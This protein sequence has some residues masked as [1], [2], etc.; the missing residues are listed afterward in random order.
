MDDRTHLR[1]VL[2]VVAGQVRNALQEVVM[3]LKIVLKRKE[4][5]HIASVSKQS[6]CL[7]GFTV[8]RLQHEQHDTK[9]SV[10]VLLV[11]WVI[12][13]KNFGSTC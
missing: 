7:F 10:N 6:Q 8:G 2:T 4:P 5:M 3:G 11:E 9:M 1:A 12:L 13:F